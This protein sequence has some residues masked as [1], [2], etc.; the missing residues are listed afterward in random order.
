MPRLAPLPPALA[1][2]ACLAG[3]PAQASPLSVHGLGP[4]GVAEVGAR[5]AR[6]DDGSAGFYNPGG[7]GMGRGVRLELAPTLGASGLSAGGRDLPLADPFGIAFS[8]DATVPLTGALRDRIRFGFAGY[9]PPAAAL[10]LIARSA[11]E[12]LDPYFDNRTQR[13]V[14]L[15]A[16]GVRVTRSLAVGAGVDVLGGVSGPADVRPGATGAPEPRIDVEAT[17]VA[18]VRAGVR[19]DLSPALRLALVYRQ[20][21]SIPARVTSVA[22]VGGVPLDV[23]VN[24]R[25]ALFDPDTFVLATSFEL[26]RTSLELDAYYARWSAYAG[27]TVQTAV[28]LPGV[29]LGST[30]EP[31]L[32][33]D[34]AGLRAAATH[35]FELGERAALTARAGAGLE[36]S[37]LNGARQLRTHLVDGDKVLGGAGATLRL[38][39][40]VGEALQLGVG[41]N[42]TGVLPSQGA[43]GIFWSGSLGI[44]VDL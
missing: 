26:G 17:T 15:P 42:A 33:R 10:R 23:D 9:A 13:L 40:V 1:L 5:A 39:G 36:P 24:V 3:G 32:F 31:A 28:T 44:G 11:E 41:V 38:R 18:A 14:L 25:E 21:F 29:N 4:A 6:A 12:P 16:I 2:A 20:R 19:L 43:K 22:E 34:I 27:P 35:E 8:L 30:P 7:L 37:I